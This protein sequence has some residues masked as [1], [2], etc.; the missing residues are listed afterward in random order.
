MRSTTLFLLFAALALV[1]GPCAYGE[2]KWDTKHKIND[3]L[4]VSDFE[5]SDKADPSLEPVS[6]EEW[7]PLDQVDELLE[8]LEAERRRIPNL[9]DE[10]DEL[11][12]TT[13]FDDLAAGDDLVS[14]GPGGPGG[15]TSGVRP[16]HG[17]QPPRNGQ[18]QTHQGQQ[19][20]QTWDH[21][22]PDQGNNR[23]TVGHSEI[24][25]AYEARS[26]M[27][28]ISRYANIF[29][30]GAIPLGNPI[31]KLHI[32]AKVGTELSQQDAMIRTTM[33]NGFI[34]VGLMLDF[35]VIQVTLFV[36]G[37]VFCKGTGPT[38]TLWRTLQSFVRE[39]IALRSDHWGAVL[40]KQSDEKPDGEVARREQ[41]LENADRHQVN[42]ALASF[43]SDALYPELV[44]EHHPAYTEFL[45]T[46]SAVEIKA[47]WDWLDR[48]K[49]RAS[50][51]YRETKRVV[52]RA[53]D[54][55]TSTVKSAFNCV[56]SPVECAR[57]I[58]ERVRRNIGEL[59]GRVK[60]D[61]HEWMRREG[62]NMMGSLDLCVGV[63]AKAV[64]PV[65]GV[66]EVASCPGF[67]VR[68]KAAKPEKP[69]VSGY[70]GTGGSLFLKIGGT[71]TNIGIQ[72]RYYD[73]MGYRLKRFGDPSANAFKITIDFS[74]PVKT[75]PMAASGLV[76]GFNSP[77]MQNFRAWI[78][79][80]I[81]CKML[82]E[83]DKETVN[84][85]PKD[86]GIFLK[87]TFLHG[88]TS[89]A[90]MRLMKGGLFGFKSRLGIKLDI[91][92]FAGTANSLILDLRNSAWTTY[93]LADT[94]SNPLGNTLPWKYR[95][96]AG[97][98]GKLRLKGRGLKCTKRRSFDHYVLELRGRWYKYVPRGGR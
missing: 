91:R 85:R 98:S 88:V 95:A 18:G 20:Q 94:G 73:N 17:A 35:K 64:T 45:Q 11:L 54:R 15:P 7:V 3:N 10:D 57:K 41:Q 48:Q 14:N 34:Q 96:K 26:T 87:N 62:V 2:S 22:Q 50:A 49:Q 78:M 4:W 25:D 8:R 67:F 32:R 28:G 5:Q 21:D 61:Q 37:A 29:T 53:T 75:I 1:T 51:Y 31:L 19:T 63:R 42:L 56:T 80:A 46:G 38:A 90:I 59:L 44:D 74:F 93:A 30:E 43:G 77:V 24:R 12:E 55:V 97:M 65:V 60:R 16:G 86:M 84:L 39:T 83:Q 33:L 71:E 27:F 9:E 66:L 70:T 76:A 52:Q 72:Q 92:L 79:N 69:L 68:V 23:K 13:V 47:K 36:K 6:G 81:V 58:K 89:A 82:G 40:A